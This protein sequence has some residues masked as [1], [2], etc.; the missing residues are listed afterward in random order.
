MWL[1]VMRFFIPA[2]IPAGDESAMNF[3]GLDAFF[4][5]QIC[6]VPIIMKGGHIGIQERQL[7]TFVVPV[8][9]R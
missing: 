7:C 6:I 4:L 5:T 3:E 9:P 1:G 2:L 8:T